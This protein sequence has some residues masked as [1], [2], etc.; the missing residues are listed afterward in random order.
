M[1]NVNEAIIGESF[2]ASCLATGYPAPK[3]DIFLSCAAGTVNNP[4]YHSIKIDNYTM[5]MMILINSFPEDCCTIYC[6]SYPIRCMENKVIHGDF[7]GKYLYSSHK[8]V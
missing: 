6:Y 3:V 5:K 4:H 8:L 7:P 1:L 2:N